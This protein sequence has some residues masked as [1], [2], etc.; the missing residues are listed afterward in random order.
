[1]S[2]GVYDSPDGVQNPVVFA[3]QR[4]M[5]DAWAAGR[6]EGIVDSSCPP[7]GRLQSLVA[8][9]YLIAV[10]ST[11]TNGGL[12]GRVVAA[13]PECRDFLAKTVA[14]LGQTPKDIGLLTQ[15]QYLAKP[16]CVDVFFTAVR[17]GSPFLPSI[18]KPFYVKQLNVAGE[19]RFPADAFPMAYNVEPV[20]ADTVAMNLYTRHHGSR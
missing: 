19:Q 12:A 17:I 8:T 10:D 18:G 20:R 11:I 4:Q 15:Q 9:S 14:E 5:L 2:V 3:T 6:L 13:C 1:M 7:G 16:D